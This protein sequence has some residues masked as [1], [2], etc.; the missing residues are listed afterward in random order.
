MGEVRR[1]VSLL[2]IDQNI[3]RQLRVKL[4]EGQDRR[5]H[6]YHLGQGHSKRFFLN[7]RLMRTTKKCARIT[8]VI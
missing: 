2:V 3:Q 6:Q 4:A 5:Q 1:M 7:R 8:N